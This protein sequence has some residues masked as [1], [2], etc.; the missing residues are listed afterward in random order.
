MFTQIYLLPQYNIKEL[1]KYRDRW[2]DSDGHQLQDKIL[3]LIRDGAGEDFLQR[4]FEQGNLRFLEN[5]W[6]LKGINIFREQID[7][8]LTTDNFEGIDF[9]YCSFHHSTFKNATF[10]NTF[11]SFSKL[12]N[13]EFMNC[14]FLFVSFYGATLEKTKF[15]NCDFI[16]HNSI[17]NCD[18]REVKLENCF[19]P[20]N[21]FFDCKFDEQ[22][23]IDT[24]LDKSS[25]K[26][27]SNLKLSKSDLAEIFKGIKEGYTA[28]GVI[29]QA[30]MYFFKER[31]AI[32]RYNTKGLREKIA[33]FI[34]ELL[35][36]YGIKPLRVLLAIFT[37]FLIFSAVFIAK[38][39]FSEGIIL[40]AGAFF[41]F[42]ANTNY[43]QTSSGLLKF[44]YIAEAFFGISLIALF[45]TVLANYWFREK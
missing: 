19:I 11:L 25:R 20:T 43:L 34:L 29:K 15:I 42:G 32:T 40:S 44:I 8:P 41:T 14:T 38:I 45:I 2:D 23:T 17:T 31:K 16:E 35:T 30:R 18:L 3:G 9:S 13:C 33:G 39:G 27:G 21:L 22:T 10:L 24:P 7:F 5:M 6:D 26:P 4:D 1:N 37:I 12:Y 28:G 36:G